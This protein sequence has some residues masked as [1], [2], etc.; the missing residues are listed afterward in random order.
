[1]EPPSDRPVEIVDEIGI[2]DVYGLVTGAIRA[3]L[4][5]HPAPGEVA[6]LLTGDERVRTLNRD[7]RGI[8][9]PTDV[10]TFPD[11]DGRLGDIAIAVPYATRQAVRRRVGLDQELGYLAIHGALHLAGMDDE[12]EPE[13]AEM[14]REMNTIAVRIGLPPDEAWSSVLHE[15]ES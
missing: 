14:Q 3:A 7:F 9:S 1:M 11:E 15:V 5:A 10:L 12:T 6:V 2:P 4:R 8:D 13:R